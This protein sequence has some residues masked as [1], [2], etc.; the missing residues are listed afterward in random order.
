MKPVIHRVEANSPE[1]NELRAE[2]VCGTDMPR[3]LG[4][5]ENKTIKGIIASK[6]GDKIVPSNLHIE[7]GHYLEAAAYVA[8]KRCGIPVEPADPQKAV[9]ISNPHYRIGS[10]VDGKANMYH[11]FFIV[12]IKS[13]FMPTKWKKWQDNAPLNNW[14]QVQ[15]Q[16]LSSGIK[17][18][19]LACICHALPMPLIVYEIHENLELQA[20]MK[21]AGTEFWDCFNSG[22]KYKVN[23]HIKERVKQLY[24]EA[25]ANLE[26]S[27]FYSDN[28]EIFSLDE[29]NNILRI[30]EESIQPS[31]TN[32][33]FV[34]S[35]EIFGLS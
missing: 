3:L 10:T 23:K 25:I 12:E 26:I 21:Q 28:R 34:D 14:I 9:F 15:T 4:W 17:R 20:I 19:L 33:F 30:Y 8:L 7:I 11:G 13:T 22:R 16:L 1:H 35:N 2:H 31:E 6:K 29:K 18:A 24:E 32:R 27:L 5:D